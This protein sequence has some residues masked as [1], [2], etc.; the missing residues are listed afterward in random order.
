MSKTNSERAAI[1]AE[2]AILVS[3]DGGRWAVAQAIRSG[4]EYRTAVHSSETVA[5]ARAYL[6]D[7][8]RYQAQCRREQ[9]ESA[10]AAWRRADREAAKRAELRNAG[11][12]R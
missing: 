3:E 9:I 4:H 12:G 7:P 11:V 1:E 6:A 10:M 5:A 2:L 8:A